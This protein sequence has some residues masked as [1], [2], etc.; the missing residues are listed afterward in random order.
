[1][2]K[3][4]EYEDI[5]CQECCISCEKDTDICEYRKQRDRAIRRKI[6][7]AKKEQKDQE[8]KL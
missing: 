4:I 6:Y 7:K 5:E 2:R 1:M 8:G 3:V